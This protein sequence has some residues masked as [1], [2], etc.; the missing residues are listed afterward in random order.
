MHIDNPA[1]FRRLC[2]ETASHAFP[3]VLIEYQPPLGGCV[4]K[5]HRLSYRQQLASQPPLGGCVLKQPSMP[6]LFR[7]PCQPPLGGC[8]LKLPSPLQAGERGKPA[9]FRRLCVETA[10]WAKLDA[11]DGPAAFRRLCVET[12]LSAWKTKCPLPA[13]FRRLCVETLMSKYRR[14][15]TGPSR[16]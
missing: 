12:A 8:V 9:A 3:F 6:L 7:L 13:A 10:L 5:L 14:L 16:L 11:L 15:I 4:L 2:V 1:A